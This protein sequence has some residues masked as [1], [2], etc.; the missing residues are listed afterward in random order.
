MNRLLVFLVASA[1][2]L[3]LAL[4]LIAGH[5][6]SAYASPA[7]DEPAVAPIGGDQTT[8]VDHWILDPAVP[9]PSSGAAA[10]TPPAAALPAAAEASTAAIAT[11]AAVATTGPPA[12]APSPRANLI[13][14]ATTA[15]AVTPVAATTP[16]AE[17]P[18]ATADPAAPADPAST[19]APTPMVA[20]DLDVA[21]AYALDQVGLPYR[22]AA[23]GPNAFD[24]SGLTMAA[25]REIG[26]ALPHHSETQ[27]NLGRGVDWQAEGILPGDLIVTGGG[28]RHHYA[29]HVGLAVSATEWVVAPASG[30]RVTRETMPFDRIEAVRRLVEPAG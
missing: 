18:A 11:T 7:P 12:G 16:R 29:G 25:Y 26:I 3:V 8:G 2:G 9:T 17:S 13:G 1:F 27:V 5:P 10:P 4:A 15:P 14:P 24:C 20:P 21:V 22:Y 28:D 23:S 30:Q 6:S 19:E